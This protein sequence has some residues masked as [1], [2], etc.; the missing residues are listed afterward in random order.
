MAARDPRVVEKID[1]YRKKS[2]HVIQGIPEENGPWIDT[3]PKDCDVI[4]NCYW[5]IQFL[6]KGNTEKL[7]QDTLNTVKNIVY[8]ANKLKVK[9][10]IQPG[11][12][13]YYAGRGD[14]P[15]TEHAEQDKS[16]VGFGALFMPALN[17]LLAQKELDIKVLLFGSFLYDNTGTLPSVPRLFNKI[18][19]VVDNGLNL[20][21]LTHVEDAV[22]AMQFILDKQTPEKIINIVDN[23]PIRQADFIKLLARKYNSLG[24]ISI[25]HITVTPVIGEALSL[26]LTQSLT[27]KNDLL[28]SLGYWLKY[29]DYQAGFATQNL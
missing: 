14:V 2:I 13:H 8:S 6:Q 3:V 28:K 26:N 19:F 24:P 5:P 9:K 4:Y 17:Y 21:Q 18:S 27:A 25:P 23:K 22:S 20:I 15:F 12:I 7:A 10:I 11:T 16:P 29:P 1:E